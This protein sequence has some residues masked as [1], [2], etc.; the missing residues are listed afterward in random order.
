MTFLDTPRSGSM[1][2]IT[3]SRNRYGQ[4]FRSRA[5]PV[6][7]RAS[8]QA[9][10]RA[11]LAANS[12]SWRLLTNAQRAGWADLATQMSRSDALVSSYLLNGFAAYVSVN[13]NLLLVG[14]ARVLAAPALVTPPVIDTATLTLTAAAFSVAF[15]STPLPAGTRLLA[16]ASP[17]RAA[18]RSF[19][20]D[21]RFCAASLAAAATPLVLTTAY[22]A[23]FG[24]PVVGNRIF[25][26]IHCMTGGFR[27]GSLLVS[28]L[29]A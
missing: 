22:T 25:L 23:R 27:S 15:T 13:N 1:Q 21:L 3:A 19:E 2:G 14:D 5:I 18:G 9:A 6:N 12:A 4:Y 24:V 16:Y 7:P 17:Q 10:V 20:A 28:Q 8:Y 29:V 11:R 26:S